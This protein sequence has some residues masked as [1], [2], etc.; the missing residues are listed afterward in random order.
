LDKV[1][2][3]NPHQ[4]TQKQLRVLFNNIHSEYFDKSLPIDW[5]R[6]EKRVQVNGDICKAKFYELQHELKDQTRPRNPMWG[7][8]EIERVVRCAREV[9]KEGLRQGIRDID[10]SKVAE[11]ASA[12]RSP[13][14]CRRIF[15]S[16]YYLCRVDISM[17]DSTKKLV[18]LAGLLGLV[19]VAGFAEPLMAAIF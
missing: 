8:A 7:R 12:R 15:D 14:E 13:E 16:Y 3:Q 18:G 2:Q 5:S 19:A 4:W 10:W 11:L 1:R 6:V 17:S 9:Q